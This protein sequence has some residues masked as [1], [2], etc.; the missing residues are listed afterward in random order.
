MELSKE[1]GEEPKYS[2]VPLGTKFVKAISLTTI[3]KYFVN[4]LISLINKYNLLMQT[5][6]H[7]PTILMQL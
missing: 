5:K 7:M 3:Q 6:C 2:M 1:F 4:Q